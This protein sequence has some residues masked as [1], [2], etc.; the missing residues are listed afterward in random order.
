MMVVLS[1]LAWRM[2]H[3]L[4]RLLKPDDGRKAF[5]TIANPE[6][7]QAGQ[8]TRAGAAP[9]GELRNPYAPAP[10]LYLLHGGRDDAVDL[11]VLEPPNEELL[12]DINA[13]LWSAQRR[14][15]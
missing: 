13:L 5:R 12:Q 1:R 7:H 9:G 8:V 2:L 11:R 4:Q 6:A 3:L 10:T 14:S 15:G